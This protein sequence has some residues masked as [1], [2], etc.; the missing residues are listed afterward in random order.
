[1]AQ[2]N[3]GSIQ[4]NQKLA[5]SS[6]FSMRK[7]SLFLAFM[8]A[9]ISTIAIMHLTPARLDLLDKEQASWGVPSDDWDQGW[10]H[11]FTHPTSR[12]RLSAVSLSSSQPSIEKVDALMS[13]AVGMLKE[14]KAE[15]ADAKS[16]RSGPHLSALGSGDSIAAAP[17]PADVSYVPNKYDLERNA[18]YAE[19]QGL[20]KS[21]PAC[22]KINNFDDLAKNEAKRR[23]N[24]A[25]AQL[26]KAYPDWAKGL[27]IPGVGQ[28]G[29]W[30][31]DRC[32]FPRICFK[33]CLID[34]WMQGPAICAA[35]HHVRWRWSGHHWEW[36]AGSAG[37]GAQNGLRKAVRSSVMRSCMEHQ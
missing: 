16:G 33:F 10:M 27:S 22:F 19:Q 29:E 1:M 24:E 17:A 13:E 31:H 28:T 21:L 7:L 2:P 30:R 32:L 5:V 11:R 26:S 20:S 23:M 25:T 6:S 18:K 15:E 34:A 3:Y 37:A 12:K 36:R 35:A 9:A 8:F 4:T 14:L